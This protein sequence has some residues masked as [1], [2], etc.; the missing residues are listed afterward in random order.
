L[1]PDFTPEVNDAWAT[2]YG[3]LAQVMKDAAYGAPGAVAAS[4]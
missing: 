3:L 1:G 2:V 4:G